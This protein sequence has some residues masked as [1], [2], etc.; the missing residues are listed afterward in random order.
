VPT[1]AVTMGVALQTDALSDEGTWALHHWW[2]TE[3]VRGFVIVTVSLLIVIGAGVGVLSATTPNS[4]AITCTSTKGCFDA[5]SAW[6]GK[7]PFLAPSDPRLFVTWGLADMTTPSDWTVGVDYRAPGAPWT[8]DWAVTAV[9]KP[10]FRLRCGAARYSVPH[11]VSE[12]GQRFCLTP[13]TESVLFEANQ[14]L[15]TIFL[16]A[17]FG[18]STS[19]QDHVLLGEMRRLHVVS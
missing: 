9:P 6:T 14:T 17:P 3:Q 1:I 10:G 18:Y 8:L 16:T 12:N 4:T 5:M 19:R 2:Q 7:G 11:W 15:Y 13:K